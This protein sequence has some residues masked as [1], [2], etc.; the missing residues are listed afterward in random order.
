MSNNVARSGGLS[1]RAGIAAKAYRREKMERLC[2]Y[3]SRRAVITARLSLTRQ[4]DVRVA[5]AALAHPALA[6]FVHPCTSKT[7]YRDGAT[8]VVFQPLDFIARL[9]ALVPR[10]RVNLTSF[11]GPFS[12]NTSNARRSRSYISAHLNA[13]A[14]SPRILLCTRTSGILFV[15]PIR[16]KC[17]S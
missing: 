12:P 2:R 9:A 16:L 1:L 13:G 4:G 8:D 10:P 14:A 5:L 17:A 6:A 15:W 3:I 11:H 7:S